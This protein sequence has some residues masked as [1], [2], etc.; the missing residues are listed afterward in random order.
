MQ[1][2]RY[3]WWIKVP[4]VPRSTSDWRIWQLV[5]DLTPPSTTTTTIQQDVAHLPSLVM[6]IFFLRSSL[7]FVPSSLY[8]SYNTSCLSTS[9]FPFV[10]SCFLFLHY[11]PPAPVLHS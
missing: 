1:H 2:A 6:L 8:H 9:A 11:S 10:C 5:R 7:I 3:Y 4:A